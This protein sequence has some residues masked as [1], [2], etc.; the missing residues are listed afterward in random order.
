MNREGPNLMYRGVDLRVAC[1]NVRKVEPL[2]RKLATLDAWVAG[3]R[4]EQWVSRK[5]IAKVELDRDHGGIVKLNPLADWTLD[6]VWDYVHANEVPYHELFDHGYTSIGC[7][8]CTRPVKPASPSAPAAGGGRTTP[9][10][11]AASTAASS[12]PGT[13]RTARRREEGVR[14]MPFG[15]PVMLE[16]AG[17]RVVVIGTTPCARARS[18]GCSRRAPTTCSWSPTGPAPRLDELGTSRASP[19]RAAA[20]GP[21]TWTGVPVRGREPRPGRARRHRARGPRRRVLVNVM[22]DIPNCDWAAPA[23]VRRGELVLADLHGRRIARAREAAARRLAGQFGEEWS[24]VL[25]VLRAV[26]EETLPALPDFA[27]RA[28]RWATPSISTRPPAWCARAEPTSCA[29]RLRDAAARR[30]APP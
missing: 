28:R 26:R 10:R 6:Q 16:L 9:P 4:R 15:Y 20:G 5:N 21:T 24:E 3:L 11:S 12:S 1:C 14:L 8:P 23:V 29:E 17:R 13:R 2:K 25:A 27:A 7:A 19:S 30:G 22:D 18:K